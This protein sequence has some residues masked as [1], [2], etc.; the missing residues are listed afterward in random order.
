MKQGH[1]PFPTRGRRNLLREWILCDREGIT[2]SSAWEQVSGGA[3][4]YE[5]A[6]RLYVE[7]VHAVV[8]D[9]QRAGANE[10]TVVD[11]PSAGG[12]YSFR[13]LIPEKLGRGARYVRGAPYVRYT[14]PQEQGGHDAPLAAFHC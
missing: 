1:V 5:E 14:E 2:D 13:G 7:D 10:V 3:A 8:P 4:R 6:S 12:F 9:C 11:C